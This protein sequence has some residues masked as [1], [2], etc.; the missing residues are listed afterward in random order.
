MQIV[1]NAVPGVPSAARRQFGMCSE[2]L[3]I[4][5][6]FSVGSSRTP[7]PTV[8]GQNRK[9]RKGLKL[10]STREAV[11]SSSNA[12]MTTAST[13]GISRF[14]ASFLGRSILRAF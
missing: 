10:P 4:E 11:Q 1:G 12:A 13:M 14:S 6:K 2:N 8:T 9:Y 3:P 5:V 7:T